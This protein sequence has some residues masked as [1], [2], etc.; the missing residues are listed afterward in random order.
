[1]QYEKYVAPNLSVDAVVFQLINDELSILLIRRIKAPFKGSWALPGGYNPAGETTRQAT[2]RVLRSKAGVTMSQLDYIEQLYTF[3]RVTRDPRGHALS[4][5]YLCLA[6]NLVPRS[7]NST[8]HPQ[9]FP[10][11]DLPKLAYDH[12]EIINYAKERLASKILYTNVIFAFLPKL[13]TLSQLQCAYEAVLGKTLDKRNFRK[14]FLGLGL[15]MP[16]NEYHMNGAHR[17]AKL[18]KFHRQKLEYLSRSFD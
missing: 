7:S 18:Y 14:K 15:T 3:D 10:V 6:K 5:A 13:F 11:S 16:T 9:F 12:E 2:S 8:E 17:P 4:V 1:M